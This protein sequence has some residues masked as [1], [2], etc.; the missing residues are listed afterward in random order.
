LDDLANQNDFI[1][2]ERV[3]AKTGFNLNDAFGKIVREVLMRVYVKEK[4]GTS[5]GQ[6]PN[7]AELHKSIIGYQEE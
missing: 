3:S 2:A 5:A 4:G 6:T 7:D 1:S